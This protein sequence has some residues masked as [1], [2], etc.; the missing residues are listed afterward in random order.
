[1]KK[2]NIYLKG[3]HCDHCITKV[4][5][6]ISEL[7][8]TNL[9]KIEMNLAKIETNNLEEIKIKLEEKLK[10]FGYSIQNIEEIE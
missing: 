2:F 3:M 9:I 8:S 6:I 7:E 4:S 5:K 1:M 10:K